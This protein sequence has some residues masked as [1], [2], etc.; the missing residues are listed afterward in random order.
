[1]L[2]SLFVKVV[3]SDGKTEIGKI[4]KQFSGLIKEYFTDADNFGVQFPLDL[5]VTMKAAM[6]GA[7]F[8]IVSLYLAP[9]LGV[10]SYTPPSI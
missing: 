5:K 9:C 6:I 3:A 8:L 4:S 10:F 7:V 2:S 1:M